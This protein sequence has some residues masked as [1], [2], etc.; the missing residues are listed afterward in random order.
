MRE[1]V[2]HLAVWD[3]HDYGDGVEF[4]H[5]VM[6]KE[7]FLDFWKVPANDIRRA[8]GGIYDSGSSAHRDAECR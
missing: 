3:D 8:R 4:A 6:A 1:T 2:P 7:L 5:K